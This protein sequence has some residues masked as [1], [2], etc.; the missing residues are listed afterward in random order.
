[1]LQLVSRVVAVHRC[2]PIRLDSR[3]FSALRMIGF[4]GLE[5]REIFSSGASP[6]AKPNSATP[7]C[8]SL[9]EFAPRRVGLRE[10]TPKVSPLE[11]RQSVG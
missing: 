7:S 1:M 10:D 2:D 11:R 4:G 5:G 8:I 9:V 6:H 3:H